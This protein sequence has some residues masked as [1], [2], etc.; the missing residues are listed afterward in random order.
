MWRSEVRQVD[1]VKVYVK[2]PGL[3]ND[4]PPMHVL[5]LPSHT[6]VRRSYTHSDGSRG[7]RRPW[8]V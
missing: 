2:L 7:F 1:N 4:T 3:G 6:L 5:G 8:G